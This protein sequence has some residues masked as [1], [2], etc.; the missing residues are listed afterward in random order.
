[1]ILHKTFF[2][3]IIRHALS[4]TERAGLTYLETAILCL[5]YRLSGTFSSLDFFAS[6]SSLLKGILGL[7]ASFLMPAF[8]APRVLVT[9]EP[10]FLGIIWI[11]GFE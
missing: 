1:M 8:E 2:R 4:H 7:A 9:P 11:G 10:T 5:W 3:N 6:W